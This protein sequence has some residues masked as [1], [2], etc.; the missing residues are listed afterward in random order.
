M[1]VR[2]ASRCIAGFVDD[3]RTADALSP[4][5]S[6]RLSLKGARA[7]INSYLRRLGCAL[8]VLVLIAA[9]AAAGGAGGNGG[10][11][12]LEFLITANL[13]ATPDGTNATVDPSG[14]RGT[15]TINVQN[16]QTDVQFRLRGARSD[17]VYTIWT[18]FNHLGWPLPAEVKNPPSKTVDGF[19]PEANAVAPLARLDA[20]FTNGM[21]L[22]QGATFVTNGQGSAEIHLTLDY[23]LLGVGRDDGPP[24]G[25]KDIIVQCIPAS[26]AQAEFPLTKDASGNRLCPGKD[27]KVTTTWLRKYVVQVMAEQGY[28]GP[29]NDAQ[30]GA[31]CANY[32]PADRTS[33]YWQCIDPATV[34]QR[35]GSGLPR[36]FRFPFDHFRLAAH[37]DDL[38]HGF[39][40]GNEGEHVID[41]VGRRC[42]IQPLPTMPVQT[43]TLTGVTRHIDCNSP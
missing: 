38:T 8:A 6:A 32:D 22:D 20:A 16:G 43:I 23:D 13:A 29:K 18:V 39:I 27:R 1:S 5:A 11:Y 25:N 17:T 21:G 42:D 9:P 34:N 30:I 28:S 41:M 7:M 14:A 33:I 37:P 10:R 36:V 40:G 35:T 3:E 2:A 24:V 26:T 31:L 4:R 12:V 19:Y 15:M